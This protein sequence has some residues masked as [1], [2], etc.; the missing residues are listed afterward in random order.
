[1]NN[2]CKFIRLVNQRLDSSNCYIYVFTLNRFVNGYYTI[3]TT[4][5]FSLPYKLFVGKSANLG[6][7]CFSPSIRMMKVRN[8]PKLWRVICRLARMAE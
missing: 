3:V 5:P 2:L 8:Q 7:V 6:W 4:R 1:M